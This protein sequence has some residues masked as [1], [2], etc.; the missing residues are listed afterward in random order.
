MRFK[1]INTQLQ[2]FLGILVVFIISIS[3]FF[4]YKSVRRSLLVETSE[5]QL[6]TVLKAS[7]S[8][9][10]ATLER[11]I[12]TS[13]LV[14]EDPTIIKWFQ[15]NEQNEDLK[16]LSLQRLNYLYSHYDY[17]TV[18]AVSAF[19]KNY[20]REKYERLDVLSVDD[21]DDSWFFNTLKNK[22]KTTLN[23]DFNRE[24]D[25]S[26]LFVNVIMGDVS[27]PYGIAGVGV[28]PGILMS[29]FDK[30]KPSEASRLWLI[31]D[32]G[33]VIMSSVLEEINQSVYNILPR[34][35][36]ELTISTS[37]EGIINSTKLDKK[38]VELAYM[39]MEGIPY[40]LI[41]IVPVED[42]FPVLKII[43][44]Q[45][46]WFSLLF[47]L[48]T[49]VVVSFLSRSI[50]K[51]IQRLIIDSDKIGSGEINLP[52]ET[53]L[54]QRVDEFGSLARAFDH[55]RVQLAQY[56]DKLELAND[57]LSVEKKQLKIALEKASQSERL[58]Q[59]F[60]ANISHEIRT[61]MN[62][63]LGFSQLLEYADVET[64][65]YKNF[66]THIVKGGQQLLL[67]LDS[68]INL[69]KIESGVVKPKYSTFSLIDVLEET[70]LLFIPVA[71]QAGLTLEFKDKPKDGCVTFE[72][73]QALFQ[74]ILNNLISNAIKYTHNGKVSMGVNCGD[75]N[76][77]IYIADT[78]I[79][80]PDDEKE[81]IFE[82]FRRVENKLVDI[83]SGAGLGLAIVKKLVHILD[84]VIKV[85]SRINK[86]TTFYLSFSK[87]KTEDPH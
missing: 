13:E 36:I 37:A 9:F 66:V 82:P 74:L 11:A 65:E 34:N 8:N 73:D 76:V 18:F 67:I 78:G 1:K 33:K 45:T 29:E 27:S 49:L 32:D 44:V 21:D 24:L 79:G 72:S 51:P 63:I 69:S 42:L 75:D 71:E 3:G 23:Y 25:A 59:S 12:E 17:S 47:L 64:G 30:H 41:M 85:E 60:L 2:I 61:P 39:K 56:I 50:T 77:E 53:E 68:I 5:R 84:G 6:L 20:W 38:E 46:F 80:I 40:R 15:G 52:I 31:D 22:V 81:A 26:I 62:S 57:D 58:T 83:A 4:H 14:A 28:D 35:E 54:L 87:N 70:Y 43:R 10:S 16:K 48:V 19:T 86:G 7:Q 55:M